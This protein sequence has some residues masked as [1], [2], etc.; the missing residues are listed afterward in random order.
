[1]L[2]ILVVML[3][4]SWAMGK[5]LSLS[6]YIWEE[7]SKREVGDAKKLVASA[8]A[9]SRVSAASSLPHRLAQVR[10]CEEGNQILLT[11]SHSHQ[12]SR[13]NVWG[14]PKRQECHQGLLGGA[15]QSAQCHEQCAV[16]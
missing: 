1:M 11:S 6:T 2:T 9:K 4:V 14:P 8:S 10:L 15:G 12:K 5:V 13:Q 7:V 3:R 16:G